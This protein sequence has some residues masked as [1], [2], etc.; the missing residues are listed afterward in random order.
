MNY[1]FSLHRMI[2]GGLPCKCSQCLPPDILATKLDANAVL[3]L[4]QEK[5]LELA[6]VKDNIGKH[7]QPVDCSEK[8]TAEIA[9]Y[10][11]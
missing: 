10:P 3:S 2:S 4:P 11:G 6:T 8:Y 5:V 9:N 7:S 1:R